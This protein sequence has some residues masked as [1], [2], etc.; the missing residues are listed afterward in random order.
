MIS[1]YVLSVVN[2][3]FVL[4]SRHHT[5]NTWS[6][7]HFNETTE[8]LTLVL[9]NVTVT[10]KPSKHHNESQT[11]LT[12]FHGNRS[13]PRWSLPLHSVGEDPYSMKTPSNMASSPPIQPVSGKPTDLTK[14][15]RFHNKS[16]NCRSTTLM[17]IILRE[18]YTRS[19]PSPVGDIFYNKKD[20][21]FQSFWM[22]LLL[23]P[24]AKGLED[25]KITATAC[26]Y[27]ACI[28]IW[29]QNMWINFSYKFVFSIIKNDFSSQEK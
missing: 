19:I 29:Q 25:F 9:S 22:N 8:R 24:L 6:L 15:F 27:M 21:R 7:A 4:N 10:F 17:K 14:L 13:S 20:S 11:I 3:L 5:H 1:L 12:C 23:C 16:D 18:N 2:F 26:K 28:T